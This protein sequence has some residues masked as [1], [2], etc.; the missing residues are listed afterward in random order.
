M[1]QPR[2][3]FGAKPHDRF[4]MGEVGRDDIQRPGSVEAWIA[5]RGQIDHHVA[6]LH[7]PT[8]AVPVVDKIRLAESKTGIRAC[9]ADPSLFAVPPDHL[10]AI[11]RQQSIDEMMSDKSVA[12]KDENA[13]WNG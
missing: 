4:D 1:D 9:T 2:A 12:T 6:F 7:V 3:R 8:Q 11:D 5:Q 10:D 13:V